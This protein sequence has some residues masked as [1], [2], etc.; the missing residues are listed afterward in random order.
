VKSRADDR[1]PP[2]TAVFAVAAGLP[3]ATAALAAGAGLI[4][5]WNADAQTVAAFRADHPGVP[6]CARA[7]WAALVRDQALALRTGA[8]LICGDAA[9]AEQAEAAGIDPR[10]LLV[11]TPPVHVAA[12]LA[13][14]WPVIV[15]AD[16]EDAGAADP[17]AAAAT[18]AIACWLGAA[19]VRT[20]HVTAARRAIDM[21][22]SI[23]GTRPVPSSHGRP[24]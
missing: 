18:A 15:E 24:R 9:E 8:I 19:A 13:A 1:L 14:G 2:G 7:D 10:G 20:E 17:Q 6:A 16:A 22:A 12:L 3:A 5:L 23:R 4:D 21:T 11:Q